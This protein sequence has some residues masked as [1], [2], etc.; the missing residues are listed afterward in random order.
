MCFFL[1]AFSGEKPIPSLFTKGATFHYAYKGTNGQ[2]QGVAVAKVDEAFTRNDTNFSISNVK[3]Y[4]SEKGKLMAKGEFR[5]EKTGNTFLSECTNLVPPNVKYD[6]LQNVYIAGKPLVYPLHPDSAISL[7]GDSIF[8]RYEWKDKK[9]SSSYR[10]TGRRLIRKDS[11][12][13]PAGRFL[14]WQ[15]NYTESIRLP[16]MKPTDPPKS[17]QVE[18]WYNPQL[19]IIKVVYRINGV[20]DQTRILTEIE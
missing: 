19:G 4:K 3:W 7:E 20:I 11:I 6:R 15:V 1:F 5:F 10:I 12:D 17:R 16:A 8:I 14:A 2:L 13:T 18:E 9:E